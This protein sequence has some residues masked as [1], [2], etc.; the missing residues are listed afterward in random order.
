MR[1]GTKALV[2]SSLLLVC[3]A[4]YAAQTASQQEAATALASDFDFLEGKWDI[5]YNSKAPG[6]PPN[7]RGTWIGSKQAE[8]RVLY[9]EFRLFGPNGN[10][11]VL[12]L[13]YRVFDH[14]KNRWDI[15]YVG[16]L[17]PSPDGSVKQTAN[18][19]ELTAWREGSMIR[20]D[21]KGSGSQLRITYYDIATDHFR[22]KADVS[23]DGGKTWNQD[24]IR[25]DA[26]R[27]Q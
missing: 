27:A 4:V 21:Q 10:T 7:I 6:I 8:G 19:A 14:V 20:V 11:I 12:G 26:K 22:W 24:Q 17:T 1:A 16:V 5:T 23:T 15:R 13:T 9:D 25:I 2:A 18:W 3:L